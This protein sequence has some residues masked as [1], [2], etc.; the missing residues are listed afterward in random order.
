MEVSN[1]VFY[2]QSTFAVTWGVVWGG[3]G[4]GRGSLCQYRNVSVAWKLIVVTLKVDRF[5]LFL[6]AKFLS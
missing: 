2:A 5:I 4:E 3:G 6:C 1:L